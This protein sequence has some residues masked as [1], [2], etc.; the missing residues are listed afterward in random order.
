MTKRVWRGVLDAVPP[1]FASCLREPAFSVEDVTFCLWRRYGDP[2][3]RSGPVVFPPDRTLPWHAH[4]YGCVAVVVDGV[5]GK[6]F[7]RLEADAG[8]GTLVSM[9]PEAGPAAGRGCSAADRW[10]A[11]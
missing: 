10:T 5:V 2:A 11:G 3:W 6:R 8:A 4:P 7:R 9:P 1:E